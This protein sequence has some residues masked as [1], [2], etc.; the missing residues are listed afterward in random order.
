MLTEAQL[1]QRK[2]G[3]G[4][5]DVA[6]ILGLSPW[7][8]P[9]RLWSEKC[10]FIEPDPP[11][12]YMEWGHRLEVPV[13][14]KFMHEHPDWKVNLANTTHRVDEIL[15]ATP[16]AYIIDDDNQKGVLEI[17]T[18]SGAEWD[19]V[20]EHYR[21]QLQHYLYALD[22]SYGYFAVL[23]NGNTYREYGPVYCDRD[24]YEETVL[25]EIKKFMKAVKK[26]LPVNI[27]PV[28][29][30]DFR[31]KYSP[32]SGDSLELNEE[33]SQIVGELQT[34]KKEIEEHESRCKE[35]RK[36]LA[37][38]MQDAK[39]IVDREGK[40]VVTAV[41]YK[42]RVSVD[43]KRLEKEQPELFERYAKVGKP[44]RVYRV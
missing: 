29:L 33:L 31:L 13:A 34:R 6:V 22:L 39:R 42:G 10:G 16:D 43:A 35:L 21:L 32:L 25:P 30:E 26:K 11:N 44:Y 20:P 23:F 19:E 12:E 3:V 2:T 15:L 4:G 18:A 24:A 7:K 28:D 1:E 8:T 5:S 40:V 37:E 38:A 14:G 17:K 36:C 41:D 27:A 9:L